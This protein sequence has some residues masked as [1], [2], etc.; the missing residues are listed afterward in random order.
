MSYEILISN[1]N[2]EII[3]LII[4][5]VLITELSSFAIN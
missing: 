3:L 4:V 1:E 2:Y 5:T